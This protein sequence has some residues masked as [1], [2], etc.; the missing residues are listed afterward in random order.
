MSARYTTRPLTDRA[1][2]NPGKREGSRFTAGWSQTLDLLVRE[3]EMLEGRNL[4]IGIDAQEGDFKRNGELYARA[5][6]P[7]PAVEVAFESKY[8]PLLYRCDRYDT[9]PWHNKMELWQHNVR[10]VALTLEALRAVDRY[11]ATATGQQYTGFKA[12]GS[13]RAAESAPMSYQ[14]AYDFL[15]SEEA[16]GIVGGEGLTLRMAWKLAARMHHPDYGHG[17]EMWAKVDA[18]RRVLREH[19]EEL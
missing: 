5:K 1:W 18:A 3:V 2:L 7:T 4:V 6:L 16:T 9:T 17:G 14:E 11:G 15:K 19:G 10:A 13:G 8:G 12:I